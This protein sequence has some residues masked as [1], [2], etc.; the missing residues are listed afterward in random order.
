MAVEVC[1][2]LFI[3]SSFSFPSPTHPSTA[4]SGNK[5][6]N[7]SKVNTAEDGVALEADTKAVVADTPAIANGQRKKTSST[8]ES[9]WIRR[10]A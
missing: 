5:K 7:N 4:G 10:S 6:A 8:W 1:V 9:T 3:A 2:P